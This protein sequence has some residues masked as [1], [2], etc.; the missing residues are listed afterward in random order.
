M[1]VSKDL[2]H[3]VR[4][5][6]TDLCNKLGIKNELAI[7]S[8]YTAIEYVLDVK[9]DIKLGIECLKAYDIY[10]NIIEVSVDYNR[11]LLQDAMS[12]RYRLYENGMQVD[13]TEALL[14]GDKRYLQFNDWIVMADDIEVAQYIMEKCP[15]RALLESVYN[16][17]GLYFNIQGETIEILRQYIKKAYRLY[18]IKHIIYSDKFNNVEL[19]SMYFELSRISEIMLDVNKD[20]LQEFYKENSYIDTVAKGN[21]IHLNDL[22]YR[23]FK[24]MSLTEAIAKGLEEQ[25]R[26]NLHYYNNYLI[27]R[28][29]AIDNISDII[30]SIIKEIMQEERNIEQIAKN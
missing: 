22:G 13:I 2:E 10:D 24:G 26:Y 8:M 4:K 25:A 11:K 19:D 21:N 29:D 1:A 20:E 7:K 14:Y 28:K 23:L 17:K 12:E 27:L 15:M 18:N 3:Y 5:D 9:Q 6:T 16:I 30:I